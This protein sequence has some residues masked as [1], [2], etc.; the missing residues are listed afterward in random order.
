MIRRSEARPFVHERGGRLEVDFLRDP[1]GRVVPFLDR[2]CRL[3]RRLEGRPRRT[4]D[5]ALRRQERRIRDVRRLAGLR[6]TLLSLCRFQAPPGAERALEVREALFEARGRRWPPVPGDERLPY[7]EAA[8]ALGLDEPVI[9]RLL[10]ADRSDA[11]LLVRAPRLDGA[12][13]LARYNLDL[14]RAVLLDAERVVVTA[15]GGWRGIFRAVKLA[16]LMYRLEPL[17]KGRHR[18]ELTGPAA[19]WVEASRRYGGRFA[20]V[21][22]A[23]A[24]A[25]GWRIEA[26]IVREGGTVPYTLSADDAFRGW[27][28]PGRPS[29]YDSA[30][31]KDLAGQFREKLGAE[32]D[33]WTLHREETPVTLGEELLLPDFTFR[34]E[35]GRTALVELMGFWT[36]EYLEA[37]LRKVRLA[38]LDHL[39][40]VVYRGL[41]TGSQDAT[42]TEAAVEA[43][44]AE[45]VWFVNR[46]L[47]GPVM[48]A[49]E[50]VATP[51]PP[52]EV[53]GGR[54]S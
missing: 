12:R 23:V 8:E 48:E 35:D 29:R 27:R 33:G 19:E 7:A 39:V 26:A 9:D 20:R 1:D 5:E 54:P 50:R 32:R 53:S 16:R 47:I 21:V 15:R 14:A 38:G 13:L 11:Q 2:L 18:L 22:P 4:V 6:R 44:G 43:A 31:E 45:V 46:P 36:P 51:G 34:H 25:P 49:V 37:K 3:V 42:G 28:G 30:W 40:L 52:R 17:G 10:Y 41:A 24:R